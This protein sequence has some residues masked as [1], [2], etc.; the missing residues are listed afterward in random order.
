MKNLQ[1]DTNMN[2]RGKCNVIKITNV[3][4]QQRSDEEKGKIVVSKYI[5]AYVYML[6]DNKYDF[7]EMAQIISLNRL[8]L[9]D[10]GFCHMEKYSSDRKLTLFQFRMLFWV[11]TD[12]LPQCGKSYQAGT[13]SSLN[14]MIKLFS[15]TA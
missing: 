13:Q 9:P 8:H 7:M 12:W 6:L 5:F 15:H 14:Q 4:F 1:H 2:I 3:P 10:P 11:M